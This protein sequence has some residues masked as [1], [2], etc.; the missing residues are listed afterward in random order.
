MDRSTIPSSST[1]LSTTRKQ[2]NLEQNKMKQGHSEHLKS[3]ISKLEITDIKC[4]SKI[5]IFLQILIYSKLVY[6]GQHIN[7][8]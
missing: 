3:I 5:D 4:Y 8:Q 6:A 7:P 2:A 1:H